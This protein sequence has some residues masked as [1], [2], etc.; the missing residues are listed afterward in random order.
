MPY[1]GINGNPC[2]Y[3]NYADAMAAAV[4][5]DTIYTDID[6]NNY[7]YTTIG[8]IN[9]DLTFEPATNNCQTPTT[10]GVTLDASASSRVA[11]VSVG[12]QVTFTNMTLTNGT[13]SLGGILYAGDSAQIVLD[14]TDLTYG[15]ASSKGG[16]LRIYYGTVEMVNGSQIIESQTG[17]GGYG[18]GV[19]IDHGTL[20]LRDTSRIGD[21]DEGNSTPDHGGGVYMDGGLLQLYNTSRVRSNSANRGGG[22]YAEG[23]AQIEMYDSSYVGYSLSTGANSAYD[24][25]GIYL[26]GTGSAL[27]MSGNSAVRYNQATNNAGG[28]YANTG[29]SLDIDNASVIDNLGGDYGGGILVYGD[30]T[31]NIHNGSDISYNECDDPSDSHG[32]GIYIWSHGAAVTVTASTVISN[33]S[34]NF[35]GGIG[36]DGN[37]NLLINLDSAINDNEAGEYGGGLAIYTGTVTIN[38]AII[39]ENTAGL[40]G[41]GIYIENGSLYADDPDIRFNEARDFGGGIYRSGGAAYLKAMTRHGLI[42]VNRA[43]LHDGGGIYDTSGN[44]LYITSWNGFSFSI[45]TNDAADDGGGIFATYGT[46]VDMYGYIEMTSNRA[47]GDGGAIY[48]EDGSTARLNDYGNMQYRPQVLSNDANTGNGGGIYALDSDVQLYG[49]IIGHPVNGNTAHAGDG[50]GVYLENSSMTMQNTLVQNNTAADNGGGI[51]VITSTLTIDSLY[52]LPPSLVT[53][54]H[55]PEATI[56]NC[57]PESLPPN[58]YCTEFRYNTAVDDGGAIY[59]DHST[60]SIEHT[61]FYSNTADS[62][63]AFVS[64]Y[65]LVNLYDSLFVGNDATGPNNATTLIYKLAGTVGSS[66]MIAM[67]NTWADNPDRAV[68]YTDES[69]G[70]FYNNI[71]WGNYQAGS[72]NPPATTQCNDTQGGAL[73]GTGNISQNPLFYTSARGDYRLLIGSPAIDVCPSGTTPDLD[74]RARP[75]GTGYDMGAFESNWL[76][77]YLPVIYYN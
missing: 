24:G 55:S 43:L 21:Y 61:A 62:A 71:V 15:Y 41:G 46:Y 76:R 64:R 40:S 17:V 13:D 45:N 20:I 63:S 52:L 58:R 70:A 65:G 77:I 14:N 16:A 59:G 44:T 54:I 10:S 4:N 60:L 57:D 5:D 26:I 19:A 72:I 12:K 3:T 23:G 68:S 56:T 35:A 18:G 49:S 31:A 7:Y 48:L 39:Q 28:I 67:N 8:T 6:T 22:I 27:K 33:V 51:A 9:K 53:D 69:S 32:A 1:I 75:K 50:G 73:S 74:N 25:G 66:V 42:G 30:T 29:S 36:I 37:S 34:N 11:Y 2:A 38:K 47:V